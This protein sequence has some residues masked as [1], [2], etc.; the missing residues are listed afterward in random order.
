MNKT[1]RLKIVVIGA[2][3]GGLA[4]A[5][6][7]RKEDARADITVVSKESYS[8]YR[9]PA[10]PSLIAGEITRLEEASIFRPDYLKSRGIKLLQGVEAV[11]LNVKGHSVETRSIMTGEAA[12]LHYD[13]LVLATG[14]YPRVPGIKGADKPGVCTF[15]TYE[16][17]KETIKFARH[18]S[19]AVVV[20]AGFIGLEIAEALMKKGLVVYFNVRSRILRR[21]L[22]PDLSQY[23]AENFKRRGLQMLKGESIGEIGG[24]EKVEFVTIEG[25]KIEASLVVFGTGVRPNV[26]LARASGIELGES[27]AI[28]VDNRMQTSAGDVYAAGDCAES[29]DLATGGFTYSPVGSI[30]ALGGKLAG[31]N[32]AGGKRQSNGFVRAQTDKI[33]GQEITSIGHSSTTARASGLKVNVH[34]IG[35]KIKNTNENGLSHRYPAEVRVLV[36]D[37]D[38]IVGAQ[39]V[40]ERYSSQ[41]SYGLLKAVLEHTALDEFLT[42]WKLP[43]DAAA[44]TVALLSPSFSS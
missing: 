43:L 37:A 32:A 40:A 19:T 8:P 33:L 29:P 20:G 17:A 35:R 6:S 1:N 11:R 4:A 7:A 41:Y 9:R 15:T 14:G 2:S 23:L 36:D 30:A 27:G 12:E 38:R 21:L 13:S 42:Q 22:E 18:A 26:D 16:A 5:L 3:A 25:K 24:G 34:D 44:G 10:I 39:V 31:A 28:R